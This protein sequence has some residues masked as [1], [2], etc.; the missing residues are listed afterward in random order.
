[1]YVI[2]ELPKAMITSQQIDRTMN[3]LDAP[4]SYNFRMDLWVLLRGKSLSV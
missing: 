4:L 2:V 3:S 1:L